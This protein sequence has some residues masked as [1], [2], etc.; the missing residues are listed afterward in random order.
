MEDYTRAPFFSD[1][2]DK[3]YLKFS[4]KLNLCKILYSVCAKM[5]LSL[6]FTVGSG[7]R[8]VGETINNGNTKRM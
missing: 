1:N 3:N 2:F 7:L 4:S 5:K 6:A 8:P